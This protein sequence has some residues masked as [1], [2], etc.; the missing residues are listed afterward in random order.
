MRRGVRLFIFSKNTMAW[1]VQFDTQMLKDGYTPTEAMV[2]GYLW[3]ISR[4]ARDLEFTTS[5]WLMVKNLCISRRAIIYAI[6]KLEETNLIE[7]YRSYK[8]KNTYIISDMDNY[9][10]MSNYKEHKAMLE[11]EKHQWN[12]W[13]KWNKMEQNI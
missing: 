11:S 12:K 1:I 10:A 7:V 3:H 6:E 13:N 8:T 9:P 2:Y 4:K 5:I